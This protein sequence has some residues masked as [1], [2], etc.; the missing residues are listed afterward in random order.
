MGRGGGDGSSGG[1]MKIGI[2]EACIKD[3]TE[4]ERGGKNGERKFEKRVDGDGD[5]VVESGEGRVYGFSR[6]IKKTTYGA[7]L[8]VKDD[9]F[10]IGTV[11]SRKG[12]L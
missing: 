11:G 7:C 4:T 12:I 6:E 9:G 2:R 3:R 1:E 8:P 5:G 10:H